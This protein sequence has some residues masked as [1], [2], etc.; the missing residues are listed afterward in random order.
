M[1]ANL[2][3]RTLAPFLAVAA[4]TGWAFFPTLDWMYGKWVTDP[5]YSHGFLVPLF[6]AFLLWRKR[7]T[8][9]GWFE[10]PMPLLGAVVLG[11]ALAMRFFAGGLLF[12]QLDAIAFLVSLAALAMVAGGLRFLKVSAPAIGFLIFMIPLPYELERNVGGPLKIAAT[13]AS[14]FLLQTVGYPAIAE[15]NVILIDDVRLGVVDACSGLKMLVTFSAFAVGA[16]LL[17]DRTKFEKLL[18]L[19]GIVPIAVVTNVLR[20]TA[21]GIAHTMVHDKDTVN[22]LHD[23]HGWLMMPAGLALLGLQLWALSRL[24]IPP[25]SGQWAVGTGPQWRPALGQGQ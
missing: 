23:L 15:G 14:T 16:V 10:T 7:E 20:V 3:F 8:A 9:A 12:H 1:T 11:L 4:V 13:Q 2:S 25:E 24:V 19:L 18:I 5:Q 6:S 17:L 22:F 21:T